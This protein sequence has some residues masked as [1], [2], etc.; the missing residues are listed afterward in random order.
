L[1]NGDNY[2]D[3]GTRV[4]YTSGDRAQYQELRCGLFDAYCGTKFEY[5]FTLANGGSFATA[6]ATAY[7]GAPKTSNP[8]D[9]GA[10]DPG[11]SSNPTTP[12]GGTSQQ[13]C[14]DADDFAWVGC[15]FIRGIDGVLRSIEANVVDILVI[16]PEAYEGNGIKDAWVVFRNI[17]SILLIIVM[18]VVVISTALGF[19]FV[20]AYT[21][22][23]ILPRLVIAVIFIQL[24]WA[25]TTFSINFI[26]VI[27]NGIFGIM[28]TPF[29][30]A[31]ATNL[32]SLIA[33][34]DGGQGLFNTLIIAGLAAGGIALGF[35][36]LLSLAFT[37]FLAVFIGFII[38]IIRNLVIILTIMLAPIAIVAWIM[39]GTNKVWSLWWDSFSKALLMFP[40]IMM[41]FAAGRIMA[42]TTVQA[43]V[44]TAGGIGPG[45]L[46]SISGSVLTVLI[47]VAAYVIPYFLIPFT[48]KFAGGLVGTLGGLANDRSR[49]IFDRNK[50]FRAARMAENLQNTKEMQ[51]FQGNNSLTK[52]ANR[53]LGYAANSG[54]A[55]LNPLKMK[56]RIQSGL[57]TAAYDEAAEKAEKNSAVRAITGN[58]DYLESGRRVKGEYVKN[59]SG[60]FVLDNLGR[61]IARDGSEKAVSA[62]LG[63]R[64]YDSKSTALVRSAQRELSEDAF[65]IVAA[66]RI[67]GTG[68]GYGG[69][70]G[71]LYSAINQAAGG[72]R[73]LANRMLADTRGIA[74]RARR[75][76]LVA[77]GFGQSSTLMSDQF[78]GTFSKD[79]TDQLTGEVIAAKGSSATP[80]AVKRVQAMS[81][82][83]TQDSRTLMSMK[84]K[85][86]SGTVAPLMSERIIETSKGADYTVQ[87]KDAQGQVVDGVYETRQFGGNSFIQE[88]ASTASK[89]DNSSGATP[90]QAE[91]LRKTLSTQLDVSQMSNEVRTLLGGS[92]LEFQR[93]AGGK[94]IYDE[95]TKQ[96]TVIGTKQT[97][98]VQDAVEAVR[99]NRTFTSL[100][101]EYGSANEAA[102]NRAGQPPEQQDDQH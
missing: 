82:L 35:L 70:I 28:L 92:I 23:K 69:G 33:G 56:S 102:N 4:N 32:P 14:E 68:T 6:D 20:D 5:D 100:R 95:K 67:A 21:V 64:G 63:S 88:L 46:E 8:T 18:L 73:D 12:G 74:E 36:G 90:E 44:A 62:Y 38:L 83:R 71:E 87:A 77:S 27:G 58:D 10:L 78:T 97:I 43:E 55:G 37:T 9:P 66:T 3:G 93:D 34:A 25:L 29:G 98:T 7:P 76:D 89:L 11:D 75:P 41:L 84:A 39:P 79:Y 13:S 60:E 101:R 19:S 26:N 96:P 31:D 24:S 22:K 57:G 51:R 54:K 91:A 86:L 59:G 49:G 61:K 50:K 30:G 81:T 99:G 48:L 52:F 1:R 15:P 42:W 45:F 40:F 85:Q 65:D 2:D 94:V 72:N 47:V 17:S 80:E 16:K 53:G